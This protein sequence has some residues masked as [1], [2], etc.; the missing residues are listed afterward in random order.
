M[1]H[2]VLSSTIYNFPFIIS[3][4]GPEVMLNNLGTKPFTPELQHNSDFYAYLRTPENQARYRPVAS[5]L[6]EQFAKQKEFT[7]LDVACANGDLIPHLP[8]NCRY[9]TF[10]DRSL[11]LV[12]LVWITILPP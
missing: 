5:F 1:Q 8:S 12:I 10:F 9:K 6:S 11:F 3:Q 2:P 4:L 7:L